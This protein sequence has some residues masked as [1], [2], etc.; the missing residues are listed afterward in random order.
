MTIHLLII[1][2]LAMLQKPEPTH[3][4]K[5]RGFADGQVI[6]QQLAQILPKYSEIIPKNIVIRK[7]KQ[8]IPLT[9]VPSAWNM[10]RAKK[11]WRYHINIST[12]SPI[13]VLNKILYDSLSYQAQ[14]GVIAHEL[15][16]VSDF[17][18]HNRWYLPKIL[19]GHL[20]RRRMDRFEFGTDHIAIKHGMGHY[21]R[22]WSA[23]VRSK[24]DHGNMESTRKGQAKERYMRPAT[25]DAYIAKYPE[26]YK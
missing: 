10:F 22:A 16:H 8:L 7:R 25:I 6:E 15:S 5:L 2:F 14:A 13:K 23:E 1:S 12:S 3:H 4:I 19:L 17:Q 24:T 21:L 20:S 18:T 9:T 11:N 26:I